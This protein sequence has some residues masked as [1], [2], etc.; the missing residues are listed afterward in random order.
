MS[1]V[2]TP[3]PRSKTKRFDDRRE[4]ILHAALR[5]L[6][7]KGIKGMTFADVA[8]RVGLNTSSVI[9]Y[10]KSKEVLAL[11]CFEHG[12]ERMGRMISEAARQPD[13]P[14][15]VATLIQLHFDI[16]AQVRR[17]EIPPTVIFSD[18]RSLTP[19]LRPPMDE[20]FFGMLGEV[21]KLFS[22]PGQGT[23]LSS[24]DYV[25]ANLLLEQLFW[26]LAWTPRYDVEDLPRVSAQMFDI[27]SRGLAQGN[28]W[29]P[30]EVPDKNWE[31]QDDAREAFLRV[32]TD[33]IN[34]RGYRG[35]SVND[36]SARLNVTKGAFYHHNANKD[37]VVV[38]CFLRSF[39]VVKSAQ[40]ASRTVPGSEMDRL[41]GA[42]CLLLRRQMKGEAQLLRTSALQA[43]PEN[44]RTEMVFAAD[45]VAHRFSGMISD[46]AKDG[47][48]RI[49]D[50]YLAANVV[51]S[52]INAAADL[53]WMDPKP[54]DDMVEFYARLSLNGLFSA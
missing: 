6:N 19:D 23:A 43:L 30:A 37:D 41:A 1:E 31:D 13:P 10:F 24:H 44:L 46:G 28:T 34:E 2:E 9:Y 47:S 38:N 15:R 7:R 16:L 3:L 50:P 42:T 27:L 25:R 49:V 14:S 39:D 5:V 32:A 17:K 8:S 36:I 18:I 40:L 26:S 22:V 20:A 48:I 45:R 33:L 52:S 12:F 53:S 21:A 29:A 11:A 54:G 4:Q 51:N 35:A